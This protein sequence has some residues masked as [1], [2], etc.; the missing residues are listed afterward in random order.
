MFC[1]GYGSNMV[2]N[3]MRLFCRAA[4]LIGPALLKEYRL[5]FTRRSTRWGAGVADVVAALDIK[6]RYGTGYSLSHRADLHRD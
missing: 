6:E 3:Q 2:A 5:A 4:K 1:F